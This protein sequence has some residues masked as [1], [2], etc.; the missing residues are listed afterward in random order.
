MLFCNQSNQIDVLYRALSDADCHLYPPLLLF[1]LVDITCVSKIFF[2]FKKNVLFN[3]FPT[4]FIV[5]YEAGLSEA[6]RFM[7][8]VIQGFI[9]KFYTDSVS[10]RD[11]QIYRGTAY[12]QE[13]QPCVIVALS[14]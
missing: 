3:L 7:H 11:C 2:I 13:K 9:F 1:V 12:C 8:L 14:V 5:F 10:V 4:G 6:C